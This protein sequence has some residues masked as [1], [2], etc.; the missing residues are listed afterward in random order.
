MYF[1][2]IKKRRKTIWKQFYENPQTTLWKCA[3]S[4]KVWNAAAM[5]AL[6]S[7]TKSRKG[8]DGLKTNTTLIMLGMGEDKYYVHSRCDFV[9]CDLLQ[10]LFNV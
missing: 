10:F 4:V 6:I 9:S 7:A 8:G 3:T 2:K 1:N 5:A